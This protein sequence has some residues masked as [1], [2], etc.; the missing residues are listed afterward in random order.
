MRLSVTIISFF[1]A[2]NSWGQH[3]NKIRQLLLNKDFTLLKICIDSASANYSTYGQKTKAIWQQLRDITSD[4]QEGWFFVTERSQE[5]NKCGNNLEDFFLV[6]FIASEKKII[7]YQIRQR[8]SKEENNEWV[9]YYPVVDSFKSE[10][11]FHKLKNSFQ[12]VYNVKLNETDLFT[13][14]VYGFRCSIDGIEPDKR[15]ELDSIVKQKD[16]LT[17]NGWLTSANAELQTYAVDG[18]YQ[19][20]MNSF[21]LTAEQERIIGIIKNK[22]GTISTCSG[23]IYGSQ[24]ITEVLAKFNFH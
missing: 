2:C 15:I 12:N 9:E 3:L 7:Y 6:S 16:I 10:K 17:L 11:D 18:F 8:K 21:K 19:L 20:K 24:T 1:I 22:H 4:Y 13:S 14:Y 5:K 23:C